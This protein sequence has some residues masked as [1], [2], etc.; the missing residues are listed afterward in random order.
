MYYTYSQ[1]VTTQL[2]VYFKEW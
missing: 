1:S 2:Q